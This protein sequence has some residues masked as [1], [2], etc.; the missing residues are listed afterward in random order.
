VLVEAEVV[1]A[2]HRG[3]V[4]LDEHSTAN[5][6]L[7]DSAQEPDPSSAGTRTGLAEDDRVAVGTD[8]AF[9][10]LEAVRVVG[11][12]G[13][14][15][16]VAFRI[17]RV[18]RS[19]PMAGVRR[20]VEH[21]PVELAARQVA[22]AVRDELV[23]VLVVPPVV[24]QDPRLADPGLLLMAEAA[25][26]RGAGR[27]A[28]SRVDLPDPAG[29]L[30]RIGQERE[31]LVRQQRLPRCQR[32]CTEVVQSGCDHFGKLDGAAVLAERDP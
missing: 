15:D 20:A 23:E 21:E 6:L 3:E 31:L 16:H 8:D 4:P 29:P 30:L 10:L 25:H 32:A 18:E 12:T 7:V 22:G 26:A 14:G 24:R 11:R 27:L 1:R 9:S 2:A 19:D 13:L 5:G 17:E 28:R